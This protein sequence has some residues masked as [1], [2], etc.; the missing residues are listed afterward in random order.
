M[1]Q[2][3][4]RDGASPKQGG[5]ASLLTLV[6]LKEGGCAVNGVGLMGS[7]LVSYIGRIIPLSVPWLQPLEGFL[8]DGEIFSLSNGHNFNQDVLVEDPVDD[9]DGFPGGVELVIAGEVK[10]CSVP[11][12]LAEPWS[13]F[14]FSEL[15]GHQLLQRPI[16]LPKSP[17]AASVRTTLYRNPLLLQQ[18]LECD[19]LLPL[20]ARPL[21]HEAMDLHVLQ[22]I[23][24]LRH[25]FI[26]VHRYNH[27]FDVIVF[28]DDDPPTVLGFQ[29]RQHFA[30]GPRDALRI[31][32]FL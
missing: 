23:E 4:S 27:G 20:L 18:R 29:I 19:G 10:A 11:E 28:E 17:A 32:S 21:C 16:E 13:G 8:I 9:S 30:E 12:M 3:T 14:E 22:K 24:R 1:S 26:V 2:S 25:L 15:L 5:V 31:A 7:R 6:P